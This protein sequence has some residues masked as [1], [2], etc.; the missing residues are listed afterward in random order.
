[1]LQVPH[2]IKMAII[3][4][5]FETIHPFLDGNGRIGRLLMTLYLID[6]KLLRYPTLYLSYYFEQNRMEYY[7][8]LMKVRT[9]NKLSEWLE[10]F[11]KGVI[12]TAQNSIDTFMQII[13]LRDRVERELLPTLGKKSKEARNL[14]VHMYKNPILDGA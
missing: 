13:A 11:L 3:H 5:Q 4:Y 7:S 10:F 14:I 8:N 2:L 9:E 6:K 12:E 1:Q